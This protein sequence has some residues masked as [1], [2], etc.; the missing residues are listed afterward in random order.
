ML[1]LALYFPLLPLEALT[2]S[3]PS[4]QPMAVE[5]GRRLWRV[6]AAARDFGVQ[7][8]MAINAALALTPDL[9]IRPRCEAD[10]Q[11]ALQEIAGWALQFSPQ[12]SLVSGQGLLLEIGASLRLFGGLDALLRAVLGG[13]PELGFSVQDAV[14]PTPAA[15]WLAAY[16]GVLLRVREPARLAAALSSLDIAGLSLSAKLES[17]LR[18][19]GLHRIGQLLTL[20][21]QGLAK[22]IGTDALVH[23][24]RVVGRRPDPRPY[25]QPPAHFDSTVELP[26]EAEG[27]A[28]LRFA[29]H[30]LVL[31]LAGFLRGSDAGAGSLRLAFQHRAQS[32][33]ILILNLLV[34]GRDVAHLEGL[35]TTRLDRLALPAPVSAIRL[36]CDDVRRFETASEDLFGLRRNADEAAPVLIE[37]LRA[38]LGDEQV[39]G[40]NALADHRPEQAWSGT[41]ARRASAG[42][43]AR[44]LWLLPQPRP[45]E[46]RRLH[47]LSGPERIETGWWDG[48]EIARDYFVAQTGDGRRLWIYRCH[49]QRG[50]WYLHGLF[51]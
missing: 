28:P 25:W 7:P 40:L 47:R 37:R 43:V 17:R 35:I 31:T 39:H 10:E 41:S 13:L 11:R 29:L 30:R 49:A 15:A 27:G 5:L 38:R 34:P 22:R 23:L 3:E 32:P 18:G 12:I 48:R 16:L 14:S 51:A 26:V 50:V 8:D 9:R 6:N 21:R 19:M 20:P 45:I 36:V 44:P 4:E 2:R 33:T 42:Y 1:W 46:S 24:D